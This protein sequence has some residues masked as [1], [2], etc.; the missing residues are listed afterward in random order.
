[1]ECFRAAFEQAAAA[2]GA[3]GAAVDAK[4]LDYAAE[5]DL[6]SGSVYG[7]QCR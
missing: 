5:V 2:D 3:F 7:Q 1:M 6:L 4:A